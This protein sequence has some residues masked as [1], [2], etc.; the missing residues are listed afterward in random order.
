MA[1]ISTAT[2]SAPEL[3]LNVADRIAEMATLMPEAIAVACPRRSSRGY[4]G[5]SRGD[6]GAMY[7]TTTFA[8]LDGDVDRI[9]SGLI[10]WGV[11]PGTR[12]ALLVK[13][14]IEFV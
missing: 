9:A 6:S 14:G 7:A 1:R 4:S 11:P 3:R 10:S 5:Q 12:L 13:P 8:E 2:I